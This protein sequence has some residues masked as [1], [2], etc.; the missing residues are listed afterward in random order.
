M[1]EIFRSRGESNPTNTQSS[2]EQQREHQLRLLKDAFD[3][4]RSRLPLFRCTAESTTTTTSCTVQQQQQ[5]SSHPYEGRQH[6]HP[7]A[8]VATT[9][10]SPAPVHH[11]LY[12][13][14][15]ISTPPVS[16]VTI[17]TN[18]VQQLYHPSSYETQPVRGDPVYD[19]KPFFLILLP[20]IFH[21]FF[22][23]SIHRSH[24][25]A[26]YKN[27]DGLVLSCPKPLRRSFIYLITKCTFFYGTVF[28]SLR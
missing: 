17:N 4:P 19:R 3:P 14:A 22:K 21:K 26:M 24:G 27:I 5:H 20:S 7:V 10:A 16:V 18:I 2:M 23:H 1:R 11:D 13:S 6:Y 15:L 9:T 12:H 28:C 25:I 8:A